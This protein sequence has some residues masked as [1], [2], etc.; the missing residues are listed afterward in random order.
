MCPVRC[1]HLHQGWKSGLGRKREMQII[2]RAK[3]TVGEG[4]QSA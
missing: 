4:K 1:V 2:K 3:T